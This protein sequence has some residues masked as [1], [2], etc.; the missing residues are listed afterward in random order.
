[1]NDIYVQYEKARNE[2]YI[3]KTWVKINTDLMKEEYADKGLAVPCDGLVKTKDDAQKAVVYYTAF[4]NKLEYENKINIDI[5][6]VFNN[7]INKYK[8]MVL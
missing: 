2:F 3:E 4:Y 1:M 5:M 8:E 6:T 7:T